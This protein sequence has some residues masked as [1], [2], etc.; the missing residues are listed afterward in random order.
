[1]IYTMVIGVIIMTIAFYM[2]TIEHKR[3]INNKTRAKY[4]IENLY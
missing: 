2:L 3:F 4:I 1:M